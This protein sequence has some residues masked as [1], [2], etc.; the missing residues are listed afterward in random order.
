M[1][2]PEVAVLATNPNVVTTSTLANGVG[3]GDLVNVIESI[4]ADYSASRFR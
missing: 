4:D 2:L 3:Y 1:R